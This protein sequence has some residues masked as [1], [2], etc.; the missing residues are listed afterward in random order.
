[1]FSNIVVGTDGS[2]TASEALS[3]AIELAR[4][5]GATLHIVSAYKGASGTGATAVTG[6]TAAADDSLRQALA[7]DAVE[8]VVAEGAHKAEGVDVVTHAGAGAPA[9]VI[10]GVAEQVGADLIVVGS[11]GMQRKV[12]GSVPNTVSHRAPCHVLIVKTA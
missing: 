10:V 4:Q 12:L 7:K 9:D 1:M 2:A 6:A 11:K 5:D 3:M 8:K